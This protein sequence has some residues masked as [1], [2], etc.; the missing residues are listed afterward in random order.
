MTN[1]K[2]SFEKG[3]E[4][5]EEIL[6]SMNDGKVALDKSLKLFEEA[7][8]I[9]NE[10]NKELSSAEQKIELLIKNRNA[11]ALDKEQKPQT[12]PFIKEE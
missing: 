2:Q 8:K 10:L 11:L 7:D 3:F 6:A 9:I 1:E 5:L 4:R 12:L